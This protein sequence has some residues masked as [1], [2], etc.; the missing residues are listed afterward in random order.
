MHSKSVREIGLVNK[1]EIVKALHKKK[2]GKVAGVV[3]GI[4]VELVS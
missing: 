3:D 1:E 2:C 4:A